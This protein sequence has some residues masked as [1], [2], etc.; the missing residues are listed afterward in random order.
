MTELKGVIT[1][2]ATPFVDGQLDLSSFK[3]LLE[4]Q[5]SRDQSSGRE[6]NHCREP[7]S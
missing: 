4:N 1:A 6:W 5:T 2:L 3:K 7:H